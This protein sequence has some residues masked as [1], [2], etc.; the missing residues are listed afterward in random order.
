MFVVCQATHVLRIQIYN[1]YSNQLSGSSAGA[2]GGDAY[3]RR[4][5][6]PLP[7]QTTEYERP[8]I[9]DSKAVTGFEDEPAS[10]TLKITGHIIDPSTGAP[11]PSGATPFV[12]SNFV[13]KLFVEIDPKLFQD[14]AL[15]KQHNSTIE[16]SN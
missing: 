3:V 11:L 8:A 10:W 1:E 14:S 13:S 5:R 7:G 4:E 6:E 16:V 12:F 15:N 9:L 2:A